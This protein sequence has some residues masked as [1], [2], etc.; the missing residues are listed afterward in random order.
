[1]SHISANNIDRKFIFVSLSLMSRSQN[2]NMVYILVSGVCGSHFQNGRHEFPMS[3]I[4]ANN[5]DRKLIIVSVSM[6][7]ESRTP[8]VAIIIGLWGLWQPFSKRPPRIFNVPYL[9]E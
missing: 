6:F 2:R 1:M 9:G 5:I 4:S 7:S 3:H 8:N